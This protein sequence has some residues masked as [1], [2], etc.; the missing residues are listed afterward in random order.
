VDQGG[1][2][3]LEGESDLAAALGFKPSQKR[4]VVRSIVDLRSPKLPIVWVAA[5][6]IP[7]F[8][9]PKDAS[10]WPRSAGTTRP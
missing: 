7:V 3:V 6:E 5:F 10:G 2:V 4:V 8:D 1:V 9:L